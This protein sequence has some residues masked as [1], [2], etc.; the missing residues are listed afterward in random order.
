MGSGLSIPEA[1][2]GWTD[3]S[4]L[5]KQFTAGLNSFLKTL[6]NKKMA[7]ED[8][9]PNLMDD[10][11]AKEPL[12]DWGELEEWMFDSIN[13]DK[14][15]FQ[16]GEENI[17]DT[18]E[19]IP[20]ENSLDGHWMSGIPSFQNQMKKSKYISKDKIIEEEE[21]EVDELVW[22]DQQFDF[23]NLSSYIDQMDQWIEEGKTFK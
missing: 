3:N 21:A 7:K 16:K 17:S 18:D 2:T 12:E 15:E 19:A 1:T 9:I 20:A 14:E 8:E 5:T 22:P 13:Q 4:E 11:P 6:K 10:C 23:Q